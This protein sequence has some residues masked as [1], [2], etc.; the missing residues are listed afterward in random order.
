MSF[1]GAAGGY[2]FGNNVPV[3]N[4]YYCRS[5]VHLLVNRVGGQSRLLSLT[6]IFRAI[7]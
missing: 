6:A 2:V 7:I 3:T 5:S 1:G 4:S